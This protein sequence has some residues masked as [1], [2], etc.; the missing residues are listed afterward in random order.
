MLFSATISVTHGSVQIHYSKVI[1]DTFQSCDFGETYSQVPVFTN[2][3]LFS[4][5]LNFYFKQCVCEI[6]C[7]YITSEQPN[8]VE[9]KTFCY[10]N[11][12]S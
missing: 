9:A 7:I 1:R 2:I 12:L 11:S 3:L 10:K 8:N 6:V 4:L 5:M